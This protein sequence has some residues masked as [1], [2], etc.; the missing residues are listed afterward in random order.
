M[1]SLLIF[2]PTTNR[3]Q[4]AK[5]QNLLSTVK[6][7]RQDLDLL[8]ASNL[9]SSTDYE[10]HMMRLGSKITAEWEQLK[11]TMV[12]LQPCDQRFGSP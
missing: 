5:I 12:T 11:G 9:F 2:P 7:Q 4:A 1:V 10:S 8:K 3:S 6:R